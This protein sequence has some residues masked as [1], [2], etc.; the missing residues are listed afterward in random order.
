VTIVGAGP[1]LTVI[2]AD[3]LTNHGRIFD[4]A[5]DGVLHLSG[6]T[7]QLGDTNNGSEA[8]GGGIRVKSGGRLDLDYC[9]IV[10]NETGSSGTGGAIY[11]AGGTTGAIKASVIT[12][13]TG[14]EQTGGIYLA[15]GGGTV[16]IESTIIANNNLGESTEPDIHVGYGRTLDSLGNNRFTS[17]TEITGYFE[18]EDSDYVGAV[19]YVVTSIVDKYDSSYD[20]KNLSLREAVR[21]A[22]NTADA[23]EIWLPAWTFRLTLDETDAGVPNL[24]VGDLDVTQN[25]TIRGIDLLTKVDATA[26]EDAAFQHIVGVVLTL[27]KVTV[28]N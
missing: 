27:D 8:D 11:F 20:A 3:D 28:I 18:L 12:V 22:N 21:Q 16:T 25:L 4:V 5:D 1:G 14:D 10:G 13:N 7:L 26:I 24:A 19:D 17:A 9:A 6:V 15:D 23:Q 2:D